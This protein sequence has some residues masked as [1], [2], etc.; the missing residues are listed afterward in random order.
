[1]AKNPGGFSGSRIPFVADADYAAGDW[2][3]SGAFFGQ[4]CETV[5][6]G[7]TGQLLVESVVYGPFAAVTVAAGDPL[8]FDESAGV[9]TNDPDT[10]T[11]SFVG[12][13]VDAVAND[14]LF[15][16]VRLNESGIDPYDAI[17]LGFISG[18]KSGTVTIATGAS[19]G[20]AS[21]GT[22]CNGKPVQVTLQS[23]TGDGKIA[24]ATPTARAVVAAGT[25]T[26]TLLD[27]DGAAT[28]NAG[29]GNQVWSYFIDAR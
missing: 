15:G 2:A 20:T 14:A 7:D 1:M 22:A 26:L 29:S 9:V 19:A 27:K 24:A 25:L 3:K 16:L 13:A 18:L 4:V 8:Y 11:N 17:L 6:T 21:V 28:V 23:T 10:G 5:A 12:V